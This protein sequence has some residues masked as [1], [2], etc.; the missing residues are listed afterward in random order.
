MPIH[1]RIAPNAAAPA[2]GL[3]DPHRRRL[4]ASVP[5][6]GLS[7][8]GGGLLSACASGP[9]PAPEPPSIAEHNAVVPFSQQPANGALPDGWA[10]YIIRRDLPRTSYAVEQ[11]DGRTVLHAASD[12]ARSGLYCPV[13]IDPA[14]AP[15][16]RWQW[17]VDEMHPE[18]T[19]GDDDAE[20][21]PVRLVVGFA[22]DV[23]KL[24][25]RDRLF[26]EQ[27]ELFTGNKLPYA[28][29]TYVWDGQLPVGRVVPYARTPR[30]QYQVVESG[31]ARLGRWIAYE[32]NVREDYRR[33]FGEAPPGHVMSVGLMTD[34]DDLKNRVEAWYGDIGLFAAPLAG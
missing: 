26:Y 10:P 17:R 16:L 6:L 8:V 15:W 33:V 13:D 29:L 4:V 7:L 24:P 22:G 9:S 23:S 27:V 5:A 32:R 14:A 1:P 25:L 31:T 11:R 21:T 3:V 34:S 28:T 19:V 2:A 18:A 20:D 30:I 12:C